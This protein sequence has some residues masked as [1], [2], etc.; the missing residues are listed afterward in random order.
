VRIVVEVVVDAAGGAAQPP[1]GAAVHVEVRDTTYQDVAAVTVA[2]ADGVV[3]AEPGLGGPPLATLEL[4]LE[5]L[6]I[7]AT[8]WAHVD[9]DG[10]GRVSLG[11]FVT[12]AS[13][14]APAVDGGRATVAVRK[15]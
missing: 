15:V 9:V 13:Y 2:A 12:M 11:D 10:D 14:P 3:A 1:A 6:P 5:M 7:V 4:D 8:I